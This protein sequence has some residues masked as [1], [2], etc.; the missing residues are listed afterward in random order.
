MHTFAV[1]YRFGAQII[2]RR[3]RFHESA[4]KALT[5]CIVFVFAG[6]FLGFCTPLHIPTSGASQQCKRKA[7]NTQSSQ[8][9]RASHW[10]NAVPPGRRFFSTSTTRTCR[11]TTKKQSTQNAQFAYVLLLFLL[12]NASCSFLF[13]LLALLCHSCFCCCAPNRL[14]SV[15]QFLNVLY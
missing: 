6:I 2:K 11:G 7:L 5:I 13:L 14:Q 4:L 3:I 15:C 12:P 1:D 10:V 8:R 9:H